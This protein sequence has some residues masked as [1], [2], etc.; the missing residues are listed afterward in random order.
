MA[1]PL[2]CSCNKWLDIIPEDTTTEAQLFQT[3]S[4]YH[5]AIN[6]L[7]QTLASSSLYGKNLSWGYLSALSQYYDNVSP[8]DSKSYSFTEKYDYASSEVLG[9]GEQIWQTGY[10][11]IANANNIL[12]HLETADEN[13][14]TDK[15]KGE[16]DLIRGEA[17]AVRALVHFDLLRLFAPAPVVDAGAKAIPYVTEYPALFSARNTTA[18]VLACVEKDL[19]E[20]A[21]LVATTDTISDNS[22][23]YLAYNTNRFSANN[24]SRDY[25]FTARGVRMH[26][27]G[28]RALLARVYAY[29]NDLTNAYAQASMI[30]KYIS[31]DD[32]WFYYTTSFSDID[33]DSGRPHKMIDEL[34]VCFYDENLSTTYTNTV[35]SSNASQNSYNL[36]NL[37]A[38]FTDPNDIRMKKLVTSVGNSVK[39]SLK[40]YERSGSSALISAENKVIP[41]VRLSEIKLIMAEYLAKNGQMDK[42]VELLNELLVARKCGVSNFDGSTTKEEF[43]SAVRDEMRRENI[44]EGQY[45]FYCKRTNA[46]TIDNN[47]VF[48]PMDGKYTMQIPD[49]Q[50]NLN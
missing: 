34:L 48:V 43:L 26:Y 17:L 5:S 2:V 32:P 19:L 30:E 18:E 45:F 36:K 46:A 15:E 50:I 9:Y 41:V 3:A 44:A 29:A 35:N 22:R 49:T 6:G 8:N 1:L 39:V 12:Q 47:G 38:I 37:N 33:T 16:I 27:V 10:N 23:T 14:F 25:F 11:V 20:A 42:A 21:D 7:Y 24:S 40:Y 13:I 31:G 28:I 4:G